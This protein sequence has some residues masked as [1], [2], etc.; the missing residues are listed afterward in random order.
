MSR[1][2][3]RVKK[4]FERNWRFKHDPTHECIYME[5]KIQ[6]DFQRVSLP[7]SFKMNGSFKGESYSS[8]TKYISDALKQ[9]ET[10]VR[11][12]RMLSD[13]YHLWYVAKSYY[14]CYSSPSLPF[15]RKHNEEFAKRSVFYFENFLLLIISLIIIFFTIK[16]IF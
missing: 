12:G 15:G 16:T 8:P 7:N 9:E 5:G 11:E 10:L 13:M 3:S 1:L 2:W 14:D 6:E 4:L